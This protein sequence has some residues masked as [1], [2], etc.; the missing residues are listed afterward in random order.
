MNIFILFKN[1]HKYYYL[2]NCS[3]IEELENPKK[4]DVKRE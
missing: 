3:R 2:K 4:S 1:I